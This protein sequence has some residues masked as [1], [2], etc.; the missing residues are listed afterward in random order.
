MEA[1][2]QYH[3]GISVLTTQFKDCTLSKCISKDLD[4]VIEAPTKKLAS[5]QRS[6]LTWD[7]NNGKHVDRINIETITLAMVPEGQRAAI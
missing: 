3:T 6:G 4:R 5:Q 1:E 2:L 7:K